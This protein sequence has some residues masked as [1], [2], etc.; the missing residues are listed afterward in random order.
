MIV[1]RFQGQTQV[2]AVED[3]AHFGHKFLT[4]I[5]VAG[6]AELTSQPVNMACPV[7]A[8]MPKVGV[9]ALGVPEAFEGACGP[10]R[11]KKP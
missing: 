8:F 5:G 4:R 9:V 11:L 1:L 7:D 3:G 6:A 10:D 2:G